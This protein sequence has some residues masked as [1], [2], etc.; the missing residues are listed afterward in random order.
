VEEMRDKENPTKPQNSNDKFA[1]QF[2]NHFNFFGVVR[3]EPI[4][5]PTFE[6]VR[7]GTTT[8]VITVH[9]HVNNPF[10]FS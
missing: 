10:A 6:S 1:N 5:K 9:A 3:P 7:E 2:E 8:T 4:F